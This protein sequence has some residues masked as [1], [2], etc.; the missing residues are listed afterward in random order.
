MEA[1]L[2]GTSLILGKILKDQ[3]PKMFSREVRQIYLVSTFC[4]GKT[5]K[6]NFVGVNK[7]SKYAVC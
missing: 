6:L 2:Y 7:I 1:P 5:V 4:R 3:R